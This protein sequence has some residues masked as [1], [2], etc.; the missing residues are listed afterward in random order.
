MVTFSPVFWYWLVG[1]VL[2]F[3]PVE[4]FAAIHP[5]DKARGG[6]FSEFVWWAFGIKARPDGRPVRYAG[7]RHFV[8]TGMCVSLLVH[9]RFEMSF[10][11]VAVFGALVGVILIRAVFW[12]RRA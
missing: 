12:E 1:L 2:L 4:L 8:L 11:P 5:K 10:V 3:L 6:T 7:A 9:F